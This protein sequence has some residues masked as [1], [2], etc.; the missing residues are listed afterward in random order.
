M[1][2][3]VNGK[4]LSAGWDARIVNSEGQLVTDVEEAIGVV[5]EWLGLGD[6]ATVADWTELVDPC[7]D[8]EFWMVPLDFDH[9]AELLTCDRYLSEAVRVGDA[10]YTIT[11]DL[12]DY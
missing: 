11:I 9:M 4:E 2:T 10:V 7:E 6:R 1:S 3:N 8:D 12:S 5:I